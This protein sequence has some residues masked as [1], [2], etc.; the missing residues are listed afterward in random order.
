MADTVEIN[1]TVNASDAVD[2]LNAIKNAATGLAAPL[3]AIQDASA[4]AAQAQQQLATYSLAA[5]LQA[6]RAMAQAD[7]SYVA[8]FKNGMQVLV[9]SKQMS[10]R[11]AL[12]YDIEYSA[13]VIEQE[14]E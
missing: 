2:G 5:T 14:E 4:Q 13:Q 3:A 12:G 1:V 8:A 11:Q 10:L 9:D 6:T 7:A